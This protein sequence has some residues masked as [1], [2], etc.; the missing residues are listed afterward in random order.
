MLF[1]ALD[2]IEIKDTAKYGDGLYAKKNFN[3]N[4]LVLVVAGK[5]IL[6]ITDYVIPIDHKLYIE[7][8]E[9]LGVSAYLNHSCEPNIGIHN[10]THVVAMRDIKVGEE[11]C[12]HYGFLGYAYGEEKTIHGDEAIHIIPRCTCGSASCTGEWGSYKKLHPDLRTRYRA[13]ISDY[14][15]DDVRYPY[16]P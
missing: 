15:L 3:K 6:Y 8:R 13:Y 2:G 5:T 10:R 11:L 9:P 14:L 16:L 12:I 4:D 7:P 1:N